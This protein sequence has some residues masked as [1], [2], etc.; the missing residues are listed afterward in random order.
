MSC[1]VLRASGNDD[2]DEGKKASSSKDNHSHLVEEIKMDTTPKKNEGE[3]I[4]GG[5]FTFI[6]QYEEEGIM[7][8]AKKGCVI[9]DAE[10]EE[11]EENQ[12]AND[13]KPNDNSNMNPHKLQ[14]PFDKSK[15]F[16][17]ILVLKVAEVDDPL[18]DDCD[19][20]PEQAVGTVSVASNGDFFL[21]YT[22]DEYL[23]FAA[24]TD[25]VP[26]A[27]PSDAEEEEE[28][29]CGDNDNDEEENEEEDEW[30]GGEG[31]EDEEEAQ[32][33]MMQMLMVAVL[34]KFQEENGRGPSSEELLVL[35]MT[36]AQKLGM[37]LPDMEATE[38]EE[39]EAED[40][41][42][43]DTTTEKEGRTDEDAS[44]ESEQSQKR[45]ADAT[46]VKD[47]EPAAKKVKIG[48]EQEKKEEVAMA[49]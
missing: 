34:R 49:Q 27:L 26:P 13:N 12:A 44:N 23:K 19:D 9:Y 2:A 30:S 48:G 20:A 24:R 29:E 28:E 14:P 35:K 18:D 38:E 10:E 5:P 8:M 31:E 39:G 32:A 45:D 4:L 6:G 47:C 1:V 17:D 7:L 41:N 42:D 21:D 25:V 22:K 40:E 33:G 46:T 36:I 43:D 11:D 15:I 16:G 3:K 37:E